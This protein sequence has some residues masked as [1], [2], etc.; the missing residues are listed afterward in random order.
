VVSLSPST[1]EMLA[2]KPMRKSIS[3][4]ENIITRLIMLY[5][6]VQTTLRGT[7]PVVNFLEKRKLQTNY[8]VEET[9]TLQKY[10]V[11]IKKASVL[12]KNITDIK[13]GISTT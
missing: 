7:L 12:K 5:N 10:I 13:S 1:T 9:L 6:I 8:S 3:A 2:P 4:K 11:F